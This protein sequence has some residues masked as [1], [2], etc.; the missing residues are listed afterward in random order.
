MR[1]KVGSSSLLAL[2]IAGL[3]VV[4][5]AWQVRAADGCSDESLRGG[6]AIQGSGTV[7]SGPFA[8]PVAFVGI[9]R[10][11]GAGHLEGSFTQ[12]LNTASGPVTL[13]V[14]IGGSY[15]V[16]ADC[17]AKDMVV[18]QLTGAFNNQELIL[19]DHAK[20]FLFV[21]TTPGAPP[22]VSGNGR[23]LSSGNIDPDQ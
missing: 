22:I 6:Y 5:N 21:V 12:R 9:L 19:I 4:G 11:D 1:S 15:T 3:L 13:N 14:P 2:S 16:N 23:K 7:M 10:F 20:E 17:T 18:N 8:G